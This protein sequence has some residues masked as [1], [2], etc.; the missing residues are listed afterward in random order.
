MFGLGYRPVTWQRMS[1]APLE[2]EAWQQSFTTPSQRPH[3]SR[4]TPKR[5]FS[6]PAC[7]TDATTS[8]FDYKLVRLDL[9][10]PI[11]M[12]AP[13]A[14]SGLSALESALDELAVKLRIDPIEFRLK[15]YAET[16]QAMGLPFSS[17]SLR[18][19]YRRGAERFGWAG[20]KPEPR[21]MRDGDTLIGWGMA[22]GVYDAVQALASAR[23]VLT[24]DGKLTVSSATADIGTGTYTIMTQIAAELLGV[25]I[26][27][28]TFEL[29]DSSLPSAPVEGDSFT[30][31]SVGSAVKAACDKV[32]EQLISLARNIGQSPL[33]SIADDELIVTD[34]QI[35]S[36]S[37]RSK[38]VSFRDVMRSANLDFIRAEAA[39]TF[40]AE[41]RHLSYSHSAVFAEVHVDEDLGTVHV[42]ENR[43]R[44]GS[45]THSEPDDRTQSDS[46]RRGLGHRDGARRGERD[47][48]AVRPVHQP[49]LR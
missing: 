27:D 21:S 18:E 22:T 34:R 40:P 32:R 20:K 17:K 41:R 31:A 23:C 1:S 39:G 43:D 2:T 6:R 48:P 36:R 37:D 4:T 19:C 9:C 44:S 26:E 30:A 45:G 5:P 16:N 15:N 3:G 24:I 38:T 10:T 49:Q 33:A 12:R 7:C 46:R 14:A 35:R 25:P 11:D 28:V 8:A 42:D 47:R 13:G 29:G